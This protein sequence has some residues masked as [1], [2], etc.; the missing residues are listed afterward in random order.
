MQVERFEL[1][2]KSEDEH[3][4]C[5]RALQCEMVLE[6]ARIILQGCYQQVGL[7]FVGLDVLSC[8]LLWGKTDISVCR[9]YQQISVYHRYIGVGVYVL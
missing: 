7:R 3:S 8:G 6:L 5:L 1:Q 4:A 9:C 2:H